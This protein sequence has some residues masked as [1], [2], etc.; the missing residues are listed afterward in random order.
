MAAGINLKQLAAEL[1]LA[2]STVSRALNDSYEISE[3]T[4][5]KVIWMAEKLNYH[6]NQFARSLRRIKAK[7]L[8]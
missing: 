5:K 8:L 2:P 3:E 4:K 7:L 1:K 6:P